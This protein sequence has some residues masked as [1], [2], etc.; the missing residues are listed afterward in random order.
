VALPIRDL[1]TICLSCITVRD[2]CIAA[3]MRC[4]T[5][6]T[7]ALKRLSVS[8]SLRQLKLHAIEWHRYFSMH[9]YIILESNKN[10]IRPI[11]YLIDNYQN[12]IL[13]TAMQFSMLQSC[14]LV[15]P[16]PAHTQSRQ[17]R[18]EYCE[19]PLPV[20]S[21]LTDRFANNLNDSDNFREYIMPLLLV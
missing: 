19:P 12:D 10:C 2:T 1:L 13:P 11:G 7:V 8:I 15:L 17:N 5:S 3:F 18:N 6:L 21:L 9:L 4:M 20:D 16:V 14:R